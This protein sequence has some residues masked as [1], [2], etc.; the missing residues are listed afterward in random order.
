MGKPFDYNPIALNYSK[1]REAVPW[2]LEPLINHI[3]RLSPNSKILEIGCGTGNYVIGLAS[4]VTQYKYYGFDISVEML[5]I[6]KTRSVVVNFVSGDAENV[7][8]FEDEHFDFCFA[9]DIIHHI[10]NIENFFN[11]TSR[12][13]SRKGKFILVTDLEENIHARSLSKFFPE[14]LQVELDRYPSYDS[15]MYEA[16]QAGLNL[17]ASQLAEG[18]RDIND[19]FI[20]KVKS[21]CSSS[22]RL[23]PDEAQKRGVERLLIAKIAGEKWFSSYTIL[24]FE[25]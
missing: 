11:E 18:F 19:D 21:K 9:V 8:P 4:S 6:A 5:K 20:D 15:I 10:I 2:V 22:M 16:K 13:L 25:K 17:K 14:I 3:S 12:C 23:I 24:I 7:F 1:T